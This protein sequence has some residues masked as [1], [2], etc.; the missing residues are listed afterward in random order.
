MINNKTRFS[1]NRIILCFMLIIS[2][3]FPTLYSIDSLCDC[4]YSSKINPQVDLSEP[5]CLTLVDVLSVYKEV[6]TP[7]A[8]LENLLGYSESEEYKRHAQTAR[9]Y[10]NSNQF[11]EEDAL[12]IVFQRE[13]TNIAMGINQYNEK[14]LEKIFGYR[15]GIYNDANARKKNGSSHK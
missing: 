3:L 12:K 7:R 6:F 10:Y 15:K 14:K 11:A 8:N 5:F 4:S 9:I 2:L 13:P 1:I